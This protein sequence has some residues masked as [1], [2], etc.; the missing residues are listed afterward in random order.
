MAKVNT[1]GSGS[2]ITGQVPEL[3]P[4]ASKALSQAMDDLDDSFSTTINGGLKSKDT[5]YDP[6]NGK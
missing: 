4:Q 6:E 2:S 3:G 5:E 1:S